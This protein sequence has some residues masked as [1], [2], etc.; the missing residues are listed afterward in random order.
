VKRLLPILLFLFIAVIIVLIYTSI[1]EEQQS[2]TVVSGNTEMKPLAI[3][4]NKTNDMQ[5]S[6]LIKS[7]KNAAQVVALDGRT[8]FFDDPGCM[9]LWL[10]DKPFKAKAKLWVHAVDVN[11]WID[12]K[13]AYYGVRDRTQMHYG[14][15]ARQMQNKDTIGYDEMRLRML[16]GENLT[17]P[18]VRK[19]LLDH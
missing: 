16:R 5:C 9:I 7:I 15:G 12:A 11:E 1:K 8:W 2:I 17:D 13:K 14:F 10:E 4:I 6:M 19:K 18:K 3:E